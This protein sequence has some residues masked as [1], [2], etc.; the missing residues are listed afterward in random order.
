MTKPS[1][2]DERPPAELVAL[3]AWVNVSSPENLPKKMRARSDPSTMAAWQRV[4]EALIQYQ[5]QTLA[6]ERDALK[7]EVERLNMALK[8]AEE[9][10]ASGCDATAYRVICAALQESPDD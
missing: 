4:S 8:E 2:K 10:M 6:A 9:E 3:A 7:A 5:N 1:M